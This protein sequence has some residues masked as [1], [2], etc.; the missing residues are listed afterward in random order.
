[1]MKWS[2]VRH[3]EMVWNRWYLQGCSARP[4]AAKGRANQAPPGITGHRGVRST[5]C[6]LSLSPIGLRSG[7]SVK[8]LHQD[9]LIVQ[10]AAPFSRPERDRNKSSACRASEH[11]RRVTGLCWAR[12]SSAS[13]SETADKMS[14]CPIPMFLNVLIDGLFHQASEQAAK[15]LGISLCP[16]GPKGS[17]RVATREHPMWGARSGA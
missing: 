3:T 15:R 4:E 7:L 9:L 10:G 2:P 16:Q 13:G 5:S 12:T 11:C 8:E 14:S 6:R 1:M 17:G